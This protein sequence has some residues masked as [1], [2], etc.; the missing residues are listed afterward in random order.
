MLTITPQ[1]PPSTL[2]AHL[3]LETGIPSGSSC[4][5]QD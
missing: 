4:I 1:H 2:Q 3:V 5:R